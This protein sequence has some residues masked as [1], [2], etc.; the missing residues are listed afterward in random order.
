MHGA[1]YL[2]IGPGLRDVWDPLLLSFPLQPDSLAAQ[3]QTGGPQMG[4][5]EILA[6]PWGQ[7]ASP[8]CRPPPSAAQEHAAE[9]PTELPNTLNSILSFICKKAHRQQQHRH[10]HTQK[11]AAAAT[12]PQPK[13]QQQPKMQQQPKVQQQPRVQQQPQLEQAKGRGA[14][15]PSSL[16]H[17]KPKG[18]RKPVLMSTASMPIQEA[19]D[20]YDYEDVD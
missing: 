13:V 1:W 15:L 6:R 4:G 7:E 18:S 9:P 5:T 20:P 14:K 8:E 10:H 2:G 12:D 17:V 16:L 11:A 19:T 3:R